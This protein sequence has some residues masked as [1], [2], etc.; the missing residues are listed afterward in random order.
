MKSKALIRT[1]LLV[2]L[3]AGFYSCKKDKDDDPAP[4][5]LTKTQLLCSKK[6]KIQTATRSSAS[7]GTENLKDNWE[8]YEF[9][10]TYLFKTN[11]EVIMDEGSMKEDPSAPQTKTG[12]WS[13]EHNETDL[14]VFFWDDYKLP[15][16]TSKIQQLDAN[17]LSLTYSQQDPWTGEQTTYSYILVH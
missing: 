1:L 6:W 8:T 2:F 9:D 7:I 16:Y 14:T 3:C 17:K 5:P 13:F 15:E 12:F 4:A 10:D 11:E